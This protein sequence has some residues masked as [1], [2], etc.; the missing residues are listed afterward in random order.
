[1]RTDTVCVI[2]DP[3]E[4]A[5]DL[6]DAFAELG[7]AHEVVSPADLRRL[8]PDRY[9][10]LWFIAGPDPHPRAPSHEATSLAAAFLKVG[11]GVYSEFVPGSPGA[12]SLW[13]LRKTGPA[14]LVMANP[15][16]VPESLAAHTILDAHDAITM[17]GPGNG[18]T[19]AVFGKV[20]GVTRVLTP[21]AE[22]WP[23]IRAGE[24][25]SGRWVWAALR[26]ADFH[27]RELSPQAL[28]RSII[29]DIVFWL[30]P[31]EA[32]RRAEE[33]RIPLRA[34]SEPREWAEVGPV[35]VIV[36]T[37]PG[38]EVRVHGARAR[39]TSPGRHVAEFRKVTPGAY[40]FDVTVRRGGRARAVSVNIINESRR[41]AYRRAL[42]RCIRWFEKSGV[43]LAA[44]GSRGVA[45]WI[46]GPDGEGNRI[47]YGKGQI[48]SPDRAD[49]LFESG[50]A[51]LVYGKVSGSVR[52]T[53]I[54]R[55]LLTRV[56]D[57]Q[58]L[59]GGDEHAGLWYTRG[60]SGPIYEDDEAWA[61]ICSMAAYRYTKDPM[62]LDR[63]LLTA[64]KTQEVFGPAS[65]AVAAAIDPTHV[66]PHDRGQM[67][68]AWL[69]AYGITRDRSFLDL[70]VPQVR[71]MASAFRT[72]PGYNISKTGE[73]SR[74]LLSLA[75]GYAY[76]KDDWFRGE[77]AYEADY[78]RSRRVAC[79]AI[80]EDGSSAA[81]RLDGTDI[82]LTYE[83]TEPVSDQLYTTS[84]AGMNLWIAHHATGE[85]IYRDDCEK[86]LDYLVRIQDRSG[87]PRTDGGWMR[88]FDY[89]LW[90]PH[91]SNADHSW[92]AWCMETGWTNAIIA[93]TLG[94][95]LDEDSFFEP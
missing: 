76:T 50:I 69:Y 49:C 55:N 38:A 58:R 28:W 27:R 91:G 44:D 78:L 77:L 13:R 12:P 57:F 7:L 21:A 63:A 30:L 37:I 18:S 2:A 84:W 71:G 9:S 17:D 54:G 11:K 85:A 87:N 31:V 60:R 20:R 1:L 65:P 4:R 51:F 8:K 32:R 53:D 86:V 15:F 67:L 64:R 42:D 73:V 19:V 29:R 82:G 66:H 70:A 22:T 59:E 16:D 92:T 40:P 93:L 94:L 72:I 34:H 52:H 35:S 74:I 80:Q 3:L 5:A 14:R 25:G 41:S 46:S 10:I 26:M 47:P 68:A 45:E 23:G 24:S 75:L 89:E 39:E 83:G 36:E 88:G 6:R 56:L 61:V 79:G 95:Y 62:F 90:E 33:R 48:F 43:L 81:D